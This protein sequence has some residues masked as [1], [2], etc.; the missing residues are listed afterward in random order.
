MFY[1][2]TPQPLWGG[3]LPGSHPYSPQSPSLKLSLVQD[4]SNMAFPE[5]PVSQGSFPSTSFHCSPQKGGLYPSLPVSY[6]KTN[7]R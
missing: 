3:V 1:L 4:S 6:G 5:R 7:D 2:I